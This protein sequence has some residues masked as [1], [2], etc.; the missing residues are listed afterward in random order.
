MS[1]TEGDP[2]AARE[3]ID[4]PDRFRSFAEFRS[5]AR[6][7]RVR[8]LENPAH[9]DFDCTRERSAEAHRFIDVD[10]ITVIPNEGDRMPN[11]VLTNIDAPDL[12]KMVEV[13]IFSF[14]KKLRNDDTT[15]GLHI[16]PMI[17][18]AD[19][20]ARTG[21]VDLS[22]RAVLYRIDTSDQN[23]TYVY[24]GT[25]EHDKAIEIARTRVLKYNETN[26]VA[27]LIQGSM[28]DTDVPSPADWK[29]RVATAERSYLGESF[30]YTLADIIGLGFDEVSAAELML[31]PDEQ[32]VLAVAESFVNPWQ[33]VAALGLAVGDALDKIREDLGFS[34]VPESSDEAERETEDDKLAR[35]LRHPAAKMQ[36]TFVENDEELE[37]IIEGGD[38][39]AWRT[40]LHPEQE[41]YATGHWNGPFR[42]TGG[43]GTGKTVVLLHRARHLLEQNPEASVVLT[44]YTR[45]LAENLARDLQL[46]A[47]DIRMAARLGEPG[48]L[49]RGVDQL[50][51][52]VRERAGRD[53]S[54]AA[55]AIVGTPALT[56]S[57]AIQSNDHGWAE[58]IAQVD[59]TLPPALRLPSFFMTEYLYV[60]LPARATSAEEYLDIRRPGRGIALDRAKRQQVWNVVERYRE[61][62]RQARTICWA[63][64]TAIASA[65]LDERG[66]TGTLADHLLVDEGQDLLPT[67]WQFLRALA[68]LGRDDMFIAEDT[69]QR[70]YGLHVVLVR[71]GIRVTG[72]SRRLTL[73]YRTTA[74][75]L[76][77]A[78][79]VL[80]AGEF[81]DSENESEG[82]G[83]YRS[84]RRGPEPALYRGNSDD[85]QIEHI[86]ELISDW[87]DESSRRRNAMKRPPLQ[88]TP[89]PYHR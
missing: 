75:N 11:V 86:A 16:E 53:F 27:E 13:K 32:L 78:M 15:P 58:A 50:A 5:H 46:L 54:A 89:P 22:W 47:P 4:D 62:S 59:P 82:V 17:K 87:R 20:R 60:V 77:Y 43:A 12:D 7:Q 19:P 33:Q 1:E 85:D 25:Y 55:S 35:A 68:R 48:V 10:T 28:P 81:V 42:L 30:N 72:R 63:E 31:Q 18:P 40:F 8:V 23:R 14:L 38:F 24:A 79:G 9:V 52:A 34:K 88:W 73:N 61:N 39:A 67:H 76:R 45:A 49:V 80:S 65:W 56:I 69:H 71:Y 70:I 37:R 41:K 44:T 57:S 51:A 66:G 3:E 83:G 64:L 36:F 74:E 29:Q 84:P 2:P 26:G 21:R 6:S